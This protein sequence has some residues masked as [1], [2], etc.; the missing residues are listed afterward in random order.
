M[1]NGTEYMP[2]PKQQVEI[3]PKH[4]ILTGLNTICDSNPELAKVCAEQIYNNCLVAA[5][6]LDDSCS[7]LGCLNNI[8]LCVVKGAT[9]NESTE[10]PPKKLWYARRNLINENQYI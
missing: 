4:P 1:Q 9:L 10:S 7:M 3:N 6:L 5:G 8:L 2:L